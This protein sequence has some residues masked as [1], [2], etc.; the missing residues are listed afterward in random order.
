MK[1][2]L[3]KMVNQNNVYNFSIDPPRDASH[4]IWIPIIL[5]LFNI[6]M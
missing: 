2:K 5:F 6:Y 3:Q 4:D 1:K